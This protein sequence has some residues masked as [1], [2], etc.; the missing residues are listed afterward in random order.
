MKRIVPHLWFDKEA[1]QAAAFYVSLFSNAKI[2]RS[3]II[4]NTPSGDVDIVEFELEGQ[5]FS[6]ISAGPDFKLNPSI[7]LIVSSGSTD[8][9]NALWAALLEGG[10][11]LMPLDAYLFSRRFGWVQDRFGL[12]WQL[13]LEDGEGSPLTISP[14]LLFAGPASGKAG[15]AVSFYTDV[16]RNSGLTQ[17]DTGVAPVV[18][19]AASEAGLRSFRLLGQTFFAMDHGF[20]A[21]F[22][23]NEAFSLIVYCDTQEQI[24]YFW[25]KLSSVP[26]AEACGWLKD[27]FGVSWQIVPRRMSEMMETGTPEQVARLTQAFLQ[28][29]KLDIAAMETAF[30]GS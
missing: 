12:S 27:P 14:Y 29:K 13:I 5:P 28:M 17:T 19:P 6:A 22:T 2:N 24:D 10:T 30:L 18:N 8:E 25:T 21:D 1:K 3:D 11:A 9:I 26:E 15:E 16:F 7:S 4:E 20:D 23:F